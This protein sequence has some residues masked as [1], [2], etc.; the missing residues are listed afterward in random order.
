[1][2]KVKQQSTKIHTTT[3]YPLERTAG[4][5]PL[6]VTHVQHQPI[7]ALMRDWCSC[8][9]CRCD[10]RPGNADAGVCVACRG[11]FVGFGWEEPLSPLC[12]GTEVCI[13]DGMSRVVILLPGKCYGDGA[14][15]ICGASE[16]MDGRAHV[17]RS[18]INGV[19]ETVIYMKTLD[20]SVVL[21]SSPYLGCLTAWK[22]SI[23]CLRNF[24]LLL[25]PRNLIP[26]PT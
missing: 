7:D 22:F 9:D 2:S 13:I 11:A 14:V 21:L 26:Y 8:R 5:I 17:R 6:N 20:C 24:G 23:Y 3:E 1:V 25:S 4:Y 15:L 10:R 16:M 18:E 12:F 19:S